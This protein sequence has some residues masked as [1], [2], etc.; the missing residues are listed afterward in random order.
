MQR[1]VT[2]V[3]E[4][5]ELA[6]LN[7]RGQA[8]T[9]NNEGKRNFCI[10]LRKEDADE[11]LRE[12]WRVKY[13]KPRDGIEEQQAFIHVAVSYAGRRPP[14]IM[15]ITGQGPFQRKRELPEDLV[16]LVDETE[17]KTVDVIIRQ[18][19]WSANGATG[20]KA[21][22]KTMVITVLEDYLEM[23]YAHVNALD[24][25]PD[26]PA[27]LENIIEAE[28]FEEAQHAIGAS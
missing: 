24:L 17:I 22:L 1:D 2:R 27:E 11:M 14:K 23:K 12:G 15:L 10:F 18:Y 16:D 20:I 4:N 8:G 9:F 25:T 19:H 5:A 28:W 21:Y 13:L 7:F 6:F 3:I 26:E